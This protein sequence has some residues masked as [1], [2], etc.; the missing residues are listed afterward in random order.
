M[1]S[2]WGGDYEQHRKIESKRGFTLP[3]EVAQRGSYYM[4]SSPPHATHPSTPTSPLG[5]QEAEGIVSERC[6]TDLNGS[7]V[8]SFQILVISFPCLTVRDL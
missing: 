4:D 7:F 1:F 5:L 3:D 8:S 6:K 2:L